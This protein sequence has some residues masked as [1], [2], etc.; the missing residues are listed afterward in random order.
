[1]PQESTSQPS[2]QNVDTT[3]LPDDSLA[4][5]LGFITSLQ[6][7]HMTHEQAAQEPSAD[8]AGT[9]SNAPQEA[10]SAPQEPV[11]AGPDLKEFETKILDGIGSLK[12]EIASLKQPK[13]KE[14]EIADIR[15]E[16]EKLKHDETGT[17]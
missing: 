16:L 15:A 12:E 5:A 17:D 11:A 1:M 8:S 10:S 14:S 6:E 3:T 4:A 2:Q 9:P 7:L 13:S